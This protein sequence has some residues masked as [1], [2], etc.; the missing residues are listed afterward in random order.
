MYDLERF[1]R[2]Q[3]ES[4]YENYERALSEIR[5]GRKQ[6]HWI[7]YIF[8]QL[9]GLGHSYKAQYYGLE[10]LDEAKE[11]LAHPVLG[12]RLIE[13]TEALLSL[14]ENIPARVMNGQIDAMK[15]QSCMTLFDYASGE[16]NSIFH[17]V[18]EKFFSGQRDENTI[19]KIRS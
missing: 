11:Y 18:L 16:E 14:S 9:K 12:K 7:W 5:A 3:D 10:N 4:P 19:Q 13:I 8:P 2:A 6:S 15:L 1:I 17:K